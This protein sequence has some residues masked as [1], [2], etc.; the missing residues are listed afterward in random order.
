VRRRQFVALLGIGVLA[1]PSAAA[2]QQAERRLPRIGYLR[3]SPANQS[4]REEDAFRQG[5]RDLGYVEGQNIQIEYRST[6]GDEGRIPVLLRELIELNVDVIVVHASGVA[7]ALNATKTIPIVMAV[8]PDLVA[9]GLVESLAHPG[10][11]VTGSTFFLAELLAKRLELL[12]ELVPSMS[13]AGVLLIRRADGA[14]TNIEVVK[15]TAKALKVELHPIEVR[16]PAEFEGAFAAWA[17]AQVGGFVMG[18]HSLLTYNAGAIAIL[19]AKQRFPS[20]GPLS[21]PENGGLMGY[22]VNFLEIFH[23]AAYFVHKILRGTKP[24]DI[25]I[26]QPTKF[27]SV[28]NLRTAKS[29]GVDI[30]TS[31]L[32]RADNVIE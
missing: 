22:G 6:E 3:L 31:I 30:P 2:A 27:K 21:L 16:G 7:A 14:N 10:G 13:R 18:D 11:N 5:L 19:A 23:R 9:L 32:L 12:K 1:W 15:T 24:G 25:P 28:V 8:G 26:E 29:L 17:D 20:I 4:Q